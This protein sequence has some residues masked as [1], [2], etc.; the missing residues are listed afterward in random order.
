[1]AENSGD[2]AISDRLA[3]RNGVGPVSATLTAR[4]FR[5]TLKSGPRFSS[6]S[7]LAVGALA[8]ALAAG[9]ARVAPYE[10]G[11]LAHPTMSSEDM[12]SAIDEH[13]RALSEG[14]VGGVSG[15]GGGCGCN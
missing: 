7:L 3:K 11:A 9:C 6:L 8:V 14:A 1:M 5:M 12:A 13:V 4:R 10:R 2:H 15:G